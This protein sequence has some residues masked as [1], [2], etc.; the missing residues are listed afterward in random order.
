MNNTDAMSLTLGES[1]VR[2]RRWLVWVAA[3]AV[4][5]LLPLVFRS[6]YALSMMCQMG[7]AVIFALS[8]NMLLGQSGLLSFGHAVYYGLGGYASIHALNAIGAG[9][10]DFPV[11]L[12]PLIGGVTGLFFGIVF[13]YAST[14]RAGTV[15]AMISLGIGELMAAGSTVLPGFGGEAGISANRVTGKGL[16]GITYGPPVQVYYLIALWLV[17][18]AILMYA[19]TQTPLGRM[20]NAVRDNPERAQF[21]GYNPQRVRFITLV[22]SAFFAGVAGGLTAINYEIVTQEY[23][24][25]HTSVTPLLMTFIGGAGYF[26]GPVLGAI[27]VTFL[28]VVLGAYTKAWP[29]YMGVVFIST[30]LF[31]P[32]G[33]A[34]IVM[35]HRQVWSAG[36][37][38]RLVPAYAK[39]FVPACALLLGTI[40]LVESTYHL[41][42]EAQAG[43]QMSL[44]R[45]PLDVATP[46]PWIGAAALIAIGLYFFRR[47]C[48]AAALSWEGITAELQRRKSP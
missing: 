41:T 42:T 20:A 6:G 30:V 33:L 48:A 39:V 5:L 29:L 7:I 27:L 34:G 9:K 31:A 13:G 21:V 38:R 24:T 35:Q 18:S 40:C 15:F 3:I 28:Q 36:L 16:F 37:M 23:L 44:F 12:L 17:V 25:A 47:S 45:I 1:K 11:T 43:T 4:P 2:S 10:L 8:Y 26:F 14:K 19:L 22:L 32:Q 46:A